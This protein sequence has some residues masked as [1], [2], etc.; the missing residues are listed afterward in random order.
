[1]KLLVL[2][3][4]SS[5]TTDEHGQGVRHI[6]VHA[7]TEGGAHA[8]RPLNE[9][10]E[11]ETKSEQC[12]VALP[13]SE[14]DREGGKGV[15]LR[16]NQLDATL[17]K[18]NG[19]EDGNTCTDDGTG[20]HTHD[21]PLRDVVRAV[22]DVE[23][24]LVIT[25]DGARH[26]DGRTKD[27]GTNQ[28]KENSILGVQV[29]EVLEIEEHTEQHQE[30]DEGGTGNGLNTRL[31]HDTN[32]D[33]TEHE[34]GQDEHHGEDQS[35]EWRETTDGENDDHGD[36]GDAH[37]D[38]DV[39]ER[40]FVPTLAFHVFL[41]TIALEGSTDVGEDVGEGA[42]HLGQTKHSTTDDGTDGNRSHR[43][44]KGDHLQGCGTAAGV[45]L[46]GNVGLLGCIVDGDVHEHR[47]RD[48]EEPT[49]DC[50]KV[51]QERHSGLH[52]PTNGEHR[53][54]QCDAD[55]GVGKGVPSRFFRP[56]GLLQRDAVNR[57]GRL[58]DF[59][60]GVKTGQADVAIVNR[61]SDVIEKGNLAVV[62][63]NQRVFHEE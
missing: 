60:V 54:S 2:P 20:H 10:T 52:E 55:I 58:V 45:I 40:P 25:N 44:G 36:E 37:E 59:S 24:V 39:L 61:L 3:A 38:G 27:G 43:L 12:Q 31:T 53:R 21:V 48:E 22:S 30:D 15:G 8:G 50:S 9:H 49:H 4:V 16:C 47:Q 42:P 7:Q 13:F 28:T 62:Q 41:A 56:V 17:C 5:D 63:P 1:M 35:S 51:D 11:E 14:D 57:T 18:L 34:G 29:Q 23:T 19:E 26:G 46:D 33:G 6:E 32:S